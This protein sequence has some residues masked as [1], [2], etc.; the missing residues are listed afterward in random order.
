MKKFFVLSV[1]CV[2]AVTFIT[3]LAYAADVTIAMVPKALDNPVFTT[4]RI[5]AEEKAKEL[6]VEL[7]WTASQKSDAAF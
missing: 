4:S 6:G 5:A 2:L 7:I 3:S 1:V